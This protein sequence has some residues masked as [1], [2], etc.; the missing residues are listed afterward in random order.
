MRAAMT[1]AVLVLAGQAFAQGAGTAASADDVDPGAQVAES[2][3]KS[4]A[5]WPRFDDPAR[6][7]VQVRPLGWYLSPSGDIGLP[8]TGGVERLRTEIEDL[9]LDEPQMT[10]AGDLQ[11]QSGA[12]RFG[13]SAGYYDVDVAL[14]ARQ[15]LAVGTIVAAPGNVVRSELKWTTAQV[16]A[17]YE[18]FEHDFG[19]DDGWAGRTVG[20]L[21]LVG[22]ARVFDVSYAFSRLTGGPVVRQEDDGFWVEPFIGVHGELQIVRDFSVDLDLN[23][24]GQPFGDDTSLS[25]DLAVAFSWRPGALGIDGVALQIGWRQVLFDLQNGTGADQFRFDGGMAGLFFGVAVR[26]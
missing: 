5:A 11:L 14:P 26:F 21:H 24:G 7:T 16:S 1:A 8:N 10:A 13:F 18:L 2:A 17:G 19:A 20:R 23:V 9:D 12:W 3:P 4:A 15:V 6:W 22:G 25:N